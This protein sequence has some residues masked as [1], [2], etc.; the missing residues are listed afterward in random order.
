MSDTVNRILLLAKE[1]GVKQS[2][3]TQLIGGYR[4]KVTDWKNGKSSPS[5]NELKIIA[6]FFNVSVSY[7]LGEEKEIKLPSQKDKDN[8]FS[9]LERASEDL[10]SDELNQVLQYINFLKSQRNCTD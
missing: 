1:R 7:L 10:T 5:K 4:G 2:F 8:I 6:D 9:Y 3:I